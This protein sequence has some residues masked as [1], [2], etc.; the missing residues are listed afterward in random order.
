MKMIKKGL[1]AVG[2]GMTYALTA[3][4]CA[5][6]IIGGAQNPPEILGGFAVSIIILLVI[7]F[8]LNRCFFLEQKD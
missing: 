8:G 6:F 3:G 7:L 2:I 1:A 4:G 5:R